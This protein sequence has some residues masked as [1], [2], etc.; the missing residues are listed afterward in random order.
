PPRAAGLA[1]PIGA[2]ART[3]AAPSAVGVRPGETEDTT[4]AEQGTVGRLWSDVEPADQPERLLPAPETPLPPPVVEQP[5]TAEATVAPPAGEASAVA[6][7]PETAAATGAAQGS[8]GGA[9]Q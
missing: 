3:R 7:A 6:E 5:A 4:L 8:E 9:G 2:P 1:P